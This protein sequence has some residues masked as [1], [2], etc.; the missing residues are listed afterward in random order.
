[1]FLSKQTKKLNAIKIAKKNKDMDLE[2][3]GLSFY[4]L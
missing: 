3:M 2:D 1:M 4:N